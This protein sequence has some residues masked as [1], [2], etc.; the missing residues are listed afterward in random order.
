MH[1]NTNT[2][3]GHRSAEIVYLLL[4]HYTWKVP[5]K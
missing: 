4:H 3:H 5:Q 1:E 2:T